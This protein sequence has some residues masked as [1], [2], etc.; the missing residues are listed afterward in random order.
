MIAMTNEVDR[1][2]ADFVPK[3]AAHQIHI[4]LV[5]HSASPS[6]EYPPANI[7]SQIKSRLAHYPIP[8]FDVLSSQQLAYT[9]RHALLYDLLGYGPKKGLI[10][11]IQEEH[12]H[13]LTHRIREMSHTDSNPAYIRILFDLD[14]YTYSS[15]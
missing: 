8:F 6:P 1:V 13:E 10:H 7:T 4:D 3:F 12:G 14:V 2:K 9:E 5:C 15:I 11:F